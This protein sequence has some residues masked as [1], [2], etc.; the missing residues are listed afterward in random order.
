VLGEGGRAPLLLVVVVVVVVVLGDEG[1]DIG[2]AL[3]VVG[4]VTGDTP[5]FL[6]LVLSSAAFSISLC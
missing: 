2:G 4:D 6:V 1:L 5:L 3:T